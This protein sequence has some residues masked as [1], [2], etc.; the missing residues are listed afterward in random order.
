MLCNKLLDMA[1]F[2]ETKLKPKMMLHLYCNL[3]CFFVFLIFQ[4]KTCIHF[5]VINQLEQVF[6][7]I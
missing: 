2:I 1:S 3:F 7:Q 5:I 6:F 4:K